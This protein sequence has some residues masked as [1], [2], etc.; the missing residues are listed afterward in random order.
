MSEQQSTTA[1]KMLTGV[2]TKQEN[3][4]FLLSCLILSEADGMSAQDG[5][6]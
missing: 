1:E 2:M 6:M 4:S 5:E 3:S